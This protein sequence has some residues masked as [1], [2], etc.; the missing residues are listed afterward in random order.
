M[1]VLPVQLHPAPAIETKVSPE[2]TVSVTV[3][4]STV[5]PVPLLLIRTVY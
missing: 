4:G 2:G 5:E 3:T 1:Q